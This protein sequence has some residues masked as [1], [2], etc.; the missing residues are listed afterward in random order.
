MNCGDAAL[1]VVH[2]F[3]GGAVSS[4]VLPHHAMLLCMDF[5]NYSYLW[6]KK[7]KKVKDLTV[8]GTVFCCKKESKRQA[9]K[10][11]EPGYCYPGS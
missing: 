11:Y 2:T 9:S 7:K 5:H 6:N 4:A 3:Q 8:I 10:P 1:Q